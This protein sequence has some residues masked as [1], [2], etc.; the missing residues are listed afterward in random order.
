MDMDLISGLLSYGGANAF[1]GMGLNAVGNAN[2]SQ[3]A[4]NPAQQLPRQGMNHGY[5]SPFNQSTIGAAG[6]PTPYMT[7]PNGMPISSQGYDQ[8]AQGQGRVNLLMQLLNPKHGQ[9]GLGSLFNPSGGFQ[10]SGPG[11]QAVS[12][13]SFGQPAHA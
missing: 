11:G 6:S 2:L 7:L 5:G 12:S 9:N 13:G 1:P 8:Y 3:Y 4:G 10:V